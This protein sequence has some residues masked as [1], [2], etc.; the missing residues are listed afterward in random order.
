MANSKSAKP[1]SFKD[2]SDYTDITDV[3]GWIHTGN[4]LYNAHVSGSILRGYP[5]G[6]VVTVAGDPK[7]GKSF[8]ALE[9]CKS[10]Q[11]MG[12]F[13]QMYESEASP[14]KERFEATKIDP[15]K[16]RKTPVKI[17][18]K[19]I[20]WIMLN[21]SKLKAIKAEGKPIPKLAYV[22]D[23]WNGLV[24]QKDIDDAV[25]GDLK[26]DMGHFQKLGK[27]LLNL[28]SIDCAELDIP[29]FITCHVYDEDIKVGGRSTGQRRKKASGGNGPLYMS[30]VVSMI[31]KSAK[32]EKNDD[33]DGK[34]ES[35][36]QTGIII[37]AR[38][39]ESRYAK[40]LPA[41]LYLDWKKGLNA[42]FGL[43][44]YV[45]WDVCG[46]DKGLHLNPT[47][48]ISLLLIGKKVTK[49]T[50]VGFTFD[51]AWLAANLS[52]SAFGNGKS[53]LGTVDH[54][55]TMGYLA[56][57]GKKYKVTKQIE[58]RF[59]ED[60]RYKKFEDKVAVL[61]STVGTYIVKH[62]PGETFSAAAVH[63]SKVFTRE[64]LE[65]LDVI[66]QPQ[67][68]FGEGGP[69]VAEAVSEEEEMMGLGT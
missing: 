54:F 42:Y 41:K 27:K 59:G 49:D 38:V 60:G 3:K 47:D 57:D 36:T 52:K 19:V 34:E 61:D 12:Y 55:V 46:V 63:Q 4:Y 26:S 25:A 28:A 67:F 9:A 35:R 48:F 50:L 17:I 11:K 68:A 69:E 64:V 15:N 39:L 22:I 5:L 33:E 32:Y 24:A 21:N 10:L 6:R 23:S 29:I 56:F 8:L 18:E 16:F 37:N 53:V 51:K 66:I 65:K 44:N 1:Y 45:S 14:D 7:A 2:V 20:H 43:L 31:T 30:S 62:L 40:A 13:I 58:E